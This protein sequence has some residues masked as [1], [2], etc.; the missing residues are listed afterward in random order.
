MALTRRHFIERIAAAGGATLAYESMTAL[1]LLAR[2]SQA[3][4]DLQGQVDGVSVVVLGAGLA[5][6]TVAY[7]LGKRGYTV[8]VLEAR[9]R[10]G[11]RAYTVRRGT[12]S[13][14]DGP[15]QECTFDEGQYFNAGAMRIAHHHGTVMAYCRE[16]GVA[17][18]PFCNECEAAYL[19]QTKTPATAVRRVRQREA[20]TDL[21]GYI[22][23]LLSKAIAQD[24]LDE[25]LTMD[26]REH[27]LAYL[28]QLGALNERGRYAGSP[29]RGPSMPLGL[30]DLLG[31]LSGFSLQQD[32][33]YQATMFQVTGGTDR[34]PAAF[35]AR[36]RDRIVYRAAVRE[37][38]QS[39]SGVSVVYADQNGRMRKADAD[40]CACTI[41]LPVLATVEAD[42]SADFKRAIASS[43]Y[44][45]AGK[46][47]LQFK[48]RF[49]EE[50]DGIYGGATRTDQEIGEIVYPSTGFHGRKG[51]LVGYYIRDPNGRLVGE[52]TPSER[53]ALALTQGERI[54]PQYRKEFES[55]FSVAWHR[56]RWNGGSWAAFGGS[57]RR[58]YYSMLLKPDGRV[59]LAGDHVSNINAWMQGAFESARSV[60]T[61]IHTR[62]TEAR[63]ARR[64]RL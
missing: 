13:E 52:R 6:L 35:A 54:H 42:F 14:E 49:W 31:S 37:I 2:P 3:P 51:V 9:P 48:R 25:P 53:L 44:T 7:E 12:L 30:S 59:Y 57:A 26:D 22:A 46:I 15:A 24:K 23:E 34:L 11:G 5:G 27:L 47:G 18:E 1:G 56:V 50:D 62:A 41:P 55:G 40:Y 8:Q 20:R 19:Y 38:R 36:L 64:I 33:N 16:L 58:E 43:T 45:A 17:I 28:R 29:R 32:Y 63:A 61:Q 39:E 21:N 4:F 10:P 60:A